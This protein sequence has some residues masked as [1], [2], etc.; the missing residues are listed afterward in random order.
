MLLPE[1]SGRS[2]RADGASSALQVTNQTARC[3]PGQEARTEELRHKRI[4]NESEA[5]SLCC[6]SSSAPPPSP[7]PQGLMFQE[8]L[9][10]EPNRDN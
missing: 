8:M 2:L 7:P 10:S 1:H 9:L 4:N 5:A 3:I 6:Y